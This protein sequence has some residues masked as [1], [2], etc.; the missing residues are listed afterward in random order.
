[1]ASDHEPATV[2][3]ASALFF[4]VLYFAGDIV[5]TAQGRVMTP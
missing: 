3:G 5:E 2:T 4:S 1:M